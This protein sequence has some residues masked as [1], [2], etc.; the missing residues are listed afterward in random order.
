MKIRVRYW[1][2]F[3]DLT[4]T[5]LETYTLPEKAS[6]GDLLAVARERHPSLHEVRKSTLAAVGVE[7][8]P[9]EHT[10]SDGDEV[11]LFPPVQGG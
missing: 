6:L 11:S 4:G 3:R 2:W 7:Y 1:S 8:R 9:P 5:E 10:L